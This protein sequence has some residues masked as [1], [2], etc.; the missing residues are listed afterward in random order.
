METTL[1]ENSE[2]ARLET[3]QGVGR[4]GRQTRAC[5]RTTLGTE[6]CGTSRRQVAP[7]RLRDNRVEDG[8]HFTLPTGL[9]LP[10]ILG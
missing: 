1:K 9:P 8:N 4:D 2:A 5:A 7:Q 6:K 3:R 10:Q